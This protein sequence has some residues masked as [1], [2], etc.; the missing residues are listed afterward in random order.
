VNLRSAF[1]DRLR[2]YECPKP[3]QPRCCRAFRPRSPHH[4]V[5]RPSF[6][7]CL[8]TPTLAS[9]LRADPPG[10]RRGCR[11]KP[12]P[13]L[14]GS[15]DTPVSRAAAARHGASAA[16]RSRESF[17]RWAASY[18]FTADATVAN[19]EHFDPLDPRRRTDFDDVAFVR[20]H[21]CPGD[22]RYPAHLTT[23]EIGLVDTDDCDCRYVPAFVGIGDGR[24]DIPPGM[25]PNFFVQ[26]GFKFFTMPWGPWTKA[27]I[28]NG[29]SGI[30]R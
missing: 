30:K 20:L 3:A 21:Q 25:D 22:R 10:A 14:P 1:A 17:R 13:D 2:P 7:C 15:P 16:R 5:C 11:T 24:A 8:P 28:Q 19:F 12:H 29:L 18:K 27:G 6:A 9:R 26:K 23:T 4:P